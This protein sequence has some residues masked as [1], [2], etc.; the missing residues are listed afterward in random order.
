[1]PRLPTLIL[2][3]F[4]LSP[5]ALGA[6]PASLCERAAAEASARHGVPLPVL[7][8]VALVETG[9]NRDGAL[10]PWP[11]A[12]NMGGPGYWP[13]TREEAVARVRHE[14]AGGRRNIDLGCFQINY[15]WH[16]QNF[17]SL[18][19]MIDPARNADYAARLLARHM[20]R[21][22]TWE[23]A[24]GAYHSG[25]PDLA[26]RYRAR[27]RQVLAG[28]GPAAAPPAPSPAAAAP[29][30][31]PAIAARSF[32]DPNATAQ[33]GSLIALSSHAARPLID[34]NRSAR[35]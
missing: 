5:P 9:H 15:H 16:G 29:L 26:A 7:R 18:E 30:Q 19:E 13:A 4:V 32:H 3:A 6:S 27:F 33:L 8:A 31:S 35:P 20:G 25:T 12:L 2:T 23:A 11:W 24:A 10:Q 17:A 1:M 28:L 34:L 21:L 14:I 22:G